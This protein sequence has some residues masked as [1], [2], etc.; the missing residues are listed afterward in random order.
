MYPK[1]ERPDAFDEEFNIM[2]TQS[3]QKMTIWL[4][5]YF[6]RELITLVAL[7]ETKTEK[8]VV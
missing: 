7:K 4:S 1:T 2:I 6:K 8:S 5:S 3:F